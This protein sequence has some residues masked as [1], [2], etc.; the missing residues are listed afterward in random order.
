MYTNVAFTICVLHFPK[1]FSCFRRTGWLLPL[2][3]LF[4][5]D[6]ISVND[7]AVADVGPVGSAQQNRLDLVSGPYARAHK[8]QATE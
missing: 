4:S 3:R 2:L 5:S 1:A 8:E 6:A 7:A